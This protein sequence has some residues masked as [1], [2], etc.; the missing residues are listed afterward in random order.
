MRPIAQTAYG[1][2]LRREH[3]EILAC[4]PKHELINFLELAPE[5][6][7]NMGGTYQC[8]LQQI[9]SKY[10]L[11]AHGLN[12]S[13]GSS[14]ALNTSFLKEVKLFLDEYNISIYSEHLSFSQ[15]DKGYLYELLPVPRYKEILGYLADRINQVQDIIQRPLVLENI[16]YYHCYP[17]QMP[18]YEFIQELIK[19][20]GCEL[21]LDINNVYVNSVNHN[22][23]ALEFVKQMPTKAIRYYH[24]AGYLKE[25]DTF[26]L[27]THGKEV[28]PEVLALTQETIKFHGTKP[29]LL[30]RDNNVP[31]LEQLCNE[32]LQ[33][34]R[35]IRNA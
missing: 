23:D 17:D 25:S 5:N 19:L 12:L 33:I 8:L 15:D 14:V 24:L 35:G 31:P 3:L 22:Y 9:A 10:P 7:I 18:E 6:W 29:V 13:I 34:K 4:K 1:I 2:G 11:I 30:E 21:L 26:L 28:T 16:S 20:S 32:L 27:D